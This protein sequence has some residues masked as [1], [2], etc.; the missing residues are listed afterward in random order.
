ML[1]LRP[2]LALA[3]ALTSFA[4]AQTT[5]TI[6]S[7]TFEG[8]TLAALPTGWS[9][10]TTYGLTNDPMGYVVA[11]PESE[12]GN[13]SSQVLGMLTATGSAALLTSAIDLT[14][15]AAAASFTLSFDYYHN[16]G[17]NTSLIIAFA[18]STSGFTDSVYDNGFK[19]VAADSQVDNLSLTGLEAYF[20]STGAA[21]WEHITLDV[22]TSVG[23]YIAA[24]NG[25]ST[26]FQIGFQNWVGGA[27][28]GA[29]EIYI[30]NLTFTATSAV[31][32]PSTYAAILGLGAFG[33]AA[34]RK[35]RTA[36]T[37]K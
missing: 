1:K 4:S 9:T 25:T 17:A 28:G 8:D 18:D 13:S 10:A 6:F 19:W 27:G 33:F 22:T 26:D 37:A 21:T 16:A 32:E 14:P 5:T 23:H 20:D 29:Q 3:C 34:W 30:D 24:T 11:N 7:A 31:P 2:L 12:A 36:L 35:R 15:H